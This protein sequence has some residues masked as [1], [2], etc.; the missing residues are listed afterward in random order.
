MKFD[1]TKAEAVEDDVFDRFMEQMNARSQSKQLQQVADSL[2]TLLEMTR[3]DSESLLIKYRDEFDELI[4]KRDSL[5]EKM[6]ADTVRSATAET[7]DQSKSVIK[8]VE[9]SVDRVMG[10][11]D[12]LSNALGRVEKMVKDLVAAPKSAEPDNSSIRALLVEI[13]K[14]RARLD[15]PQ[16]DKV[17]ILI[18]MVKSMKEATPPKKSWSFT[19]ERDDFSRIKNVTAS[20]V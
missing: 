17:G 6:L 15:A 3:R 16:E 1:P 12:N 5:M 2:R 13:A 14:V 8:A 19:I 18:D 9:E 10:R 7:K 20:S 4:K 11:T